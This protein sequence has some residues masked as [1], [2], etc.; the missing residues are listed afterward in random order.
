MALTARLSDWSLDRQSGLHMI[1]TVIGPSISIC[2]DLPS[3]VFCLS[4]NREIGNYCIETLTHGT[5]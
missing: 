2:L 1:D 5:K 4:I 3:A